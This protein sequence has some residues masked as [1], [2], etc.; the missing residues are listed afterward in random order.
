MIYWC[1]KID[2]WLGVFIAHNLVL[3]SVSNVFKSPY[4]SKQGS[5]TNKYHRWLHCTGYS[6][7]SKR[8]PHGT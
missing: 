7:G 1:G 3:A 8:F 6:L 5:V 2:V 4:G